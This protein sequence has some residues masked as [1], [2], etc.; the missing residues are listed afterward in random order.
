MLVLSHLLHDRTFIH[1]LDTGRVAIVTLADID[2]KKVR[3]G[4]HGGPSLKFYRESILS[5]QEVADLEA[6]LKRQG[7][8]P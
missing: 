6:K 8:A 3:L 4:F 7:G 5:P 2:R 1:D